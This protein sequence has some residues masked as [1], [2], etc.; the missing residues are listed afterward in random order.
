MSLLKTS[1]NCTGKTPV[2]SASRSEAEVTSP[3]LYKDGLCHK[4]IAPKSCA[5]CITLFNICQ[6]FCVCVGGAG[7]GSLFAYAFLASYPLARDT[8]NGTY[9]VSWR[10]CSNID[11]VLANPDF[12][13]SWAIIFILYC[14]NRFNCQYFGIA[15]H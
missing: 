1:E 9:H 15:H 10:V 13:R 4:C 2:V 11:G 12:F 7:R 5:K 8:L 14:S 6:L 3:K